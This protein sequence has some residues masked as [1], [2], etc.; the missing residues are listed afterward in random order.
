M[1]P[2]TIKSIPK[3]VF[4]FGISSKK[5]QP[6]REDHTSIEYSNGD[7]AAGD[8]IRYAEN[9]SRNAADAV[10]PKTIMYINENSRLLNHSRK[11]NW[12]AGLLIVLYWPLPI[13]K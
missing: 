4:K 11:I 8:A 12:A 5:N 13:K 1:P 7:I 3:N 9:I 6:L 2:H 10:K